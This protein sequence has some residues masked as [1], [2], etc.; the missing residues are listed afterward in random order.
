MSAGRGSQLVLKPVRVAVAI[1]VP[2]VVAVLL[3]VLIGKDPEEQITEVTLAYGAAEG[4]EACEYLSS[5]ALE[6]IGG[7]EGCNFTFKDV[8]SA[9]FEVQEI[10][11]DGDTATAEV[12]NVDSGT[13]IDL[14]YVE[15]EGDWRISSFPGLEQVVPTDQAPPPAAPE[16][17]ETETDPP[18]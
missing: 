16:A 15:E 12:L 9:E 1:A 7:A 11:V 14:G 18:P 6:Q 17:T 10:S 2:V 5:E 8:R 3:I 13:P 4:A